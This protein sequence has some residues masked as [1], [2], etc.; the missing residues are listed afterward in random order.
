MGLYQ[1]KL[2]GGTEVAEGTMAFQFG[3]PKDFIFK[4][5]RK[6]P[7]ERDRVVTPRMRNTVFKQRYPFCR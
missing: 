6:L 2:L 1:R 3:R 5:H 4:L 7:S